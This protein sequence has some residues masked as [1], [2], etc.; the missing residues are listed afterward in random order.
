MKGLC[1]KC[2][3]T[4]IEL[5][6]GEP[7]PICMKCFGERLVKKTYKDFGVTE[8]EVSLENLKEKWE[9]KNRRKNVN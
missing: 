9:F 2:A 1:H 4:E 6:E 8:E 5:A 7:E 3:G